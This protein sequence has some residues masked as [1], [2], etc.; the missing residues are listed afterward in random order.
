MKTI[1]R[2]IQAK[3]AN[4][5]ASKKLR[6]AITRDRAIK[7]KFSKLTKRT[8]VCT[9]EATGSFY[10]TDFIT[11]GSLGAGT[12]GTVKLAVDTNSG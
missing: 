8:N 11:I 9:I 12:F 4:L 5:D 3:S 7:A 10:G 6:K 2:K 1:T